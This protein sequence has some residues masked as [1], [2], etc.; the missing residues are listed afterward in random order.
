MVLTAST[1][2]SQT[3][4]PFDRL[5]VVIVVVGV[6][7]FVVRGLN[8]ILYP[9]LYAE[10]GAQFFSGAVDRG[11]DAL[12]TPF[13]GYLHVFPRLIALVASPLPFTVA[14]LAYVLAAV[15]AYLAVASIVLSS[16]LA[17]LLP[18]P[19][20]RAIAFLLLCLFP[21]L[22]EAYG[23]IANLIFVGG[24]GLVLVAL[25]DDPQSLRGRVFEIA[26]VVVL[27][28]SGPVVVMILPMYI[29]RWWRAGRTR[30]SATVLGAALVSAAI[31]I[32]V[33][34]SS[35][36]ST[37]GGGSLGTLV[38]SASERVGGVWLFSTNDLFGPDGPVIAKIAAALWIS[39]AV[40]VIVVALGR[41]AVAPL[42]TFVLILAVVT[43]A[44]GNSFVSGPIVLGRHLMTPLAIIVLLLVAAAARSRLRWVTI[45]ATVCLVAGL[46]G[47]IA[48]FLLV[49]YLDPSDMQRLQDCH[50]LGRTTCVTPIYPPG[51]FVQLAP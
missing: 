36:R 19:R 44:Y 14:P 22:T 48:S 41:A 2:T 51:W 28:T 4:R 32:A 21:P 50:D 34:L 42:V 17:W 10:D 18:T 20:V 43:N 1:D 26:V 12:V 9:V 47:M 35:E 38:R 39:V 49:G 8:R 31:Q 24:V 40:A 30:H 16:R 11:V 29:A 7:A 33:Y 6:G 13:A 15:A 5:A 46:Y 25:C 3:R 45:V 27:A 37:E 23:N